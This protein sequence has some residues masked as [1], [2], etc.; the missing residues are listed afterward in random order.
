MNGWGLLD[1]PPAKADWEFPPEEYRQRVE[2]A[3]FRMSAAGVDCLFLTSEKNIRYFTGFNTQT[4]VISTIPRYVLLPVDREPIAIMPVSH[5]P[6]FR[7]TTWITDIRSWLAPRP[8]DDGVSLIVDA[9]R[10]LV[11]PGGRVGAEIGAEMRLQMPVEDFLRIRD[12]LNGII[13]V[14]AG[15]VLRPLRMVKSSFEVA[16]IRQTAQIVNNAFARLPELLILGQT[17]WD[18]YRAFHRVLVELG[19]DKVPY[20]IPVS[21]ADG[22]DQTAVGPTNRVLQLGDLLNVDVCPT[23]RGYFCDFDRNFALGRS[24]DESRRLYAR[25]FEAT[26]A[27]IEAVRP[28]RTAADVWR[29]IAKV[30]APD[31]RLTTHAARMGHGIGLDL[32]EPPS[33]AESDNTVIE[34][35]MILAIQVALTAPEA[36][37]MAPRMQVHEENVVVTQDGCDLLSLRAASTLPVI[38]GAGPGRRRGTGL[39]DALGGDIN[40]RL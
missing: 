23:W 8:A 17:E 2:K 36:G 19:A 29:V 37:G 31:G 25:V 26:Q 13:F 35:G 1:T 7:A 39:R 18:F 34:A 20:L 38:M 12:A 24:T 3:R 33:L 21:G 15:H 30:L 9:L 28:N 4:W 10:S 14:D 6:G 11:R 32:T 27:G 40:E 22:Y 5:V 16:Y